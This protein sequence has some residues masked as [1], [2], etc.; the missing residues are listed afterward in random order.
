MTDSNGM[1]WL[2]GD[3][4]N[5]WLPFNVRTNPRLVSLFFADQFTGWAVG[6]SGLIVR[7][8]DGGYNP[9]Y[10]EAPPQ[11]PP[12]VQAPEEVAPAPSPAP[13]AG[14]GEGG[15]AGAPGQ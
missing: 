14:G 13:Q 5:T 4:G 2:T 10:Y 9:Q 11:Q 7:T 8:D 1:V 12:Q 6:E 15:G 3:G